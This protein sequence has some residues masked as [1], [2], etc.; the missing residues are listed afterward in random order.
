MTSSSESPLEAAAGTA[1]SHTTDAFKLLSNEARLAIL[2]A[3]WEDRDSLR[4]DNSVP[5]TELYERVGVSDSGNFTY[6][7]D[8][9]RGHFVKQTDDGYELRRAGYRVVEAVLSG[10]VVDAPILERT[11]VDEPCYYCGAPSIEVSYREGAIGMYCPECRGTYAESTDTEEKQPP[12]EQQRLGYMHLPPPGIESRTP[13]E[14]LRASFIWLVG[15]LGMA[16]N[17]VCPRCA[18]QSRTC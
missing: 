7:L 12:S 5:F 2:L 1:A 9:L 8:Q 14:V 13:R 18:A 4:N 10:A 3:L 17:G 16:V 11:R 15:E 6:H